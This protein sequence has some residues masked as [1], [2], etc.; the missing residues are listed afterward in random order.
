MDVTDVE[1]TKIDYGKF[2]E[3][4]S[5]SIKNDILISIFPSE[6]TNDISIY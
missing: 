2:R 6:Q 4:N 1:Q 3:D 5:T